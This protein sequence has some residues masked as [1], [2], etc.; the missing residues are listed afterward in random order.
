M[1]VLKTPL[2]Y[3]VRSGYKVFSSVNGKFTQFTIK[4]TSVK[5]GVNHWSP[6]IIHNLVEKVHFVFTINRK[7]IIAV[8]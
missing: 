7:I 5:E 2:A 4:Q 3:L 6:H 1:Y 8:L